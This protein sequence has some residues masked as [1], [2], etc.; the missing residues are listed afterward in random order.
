MDAAARH[1]A[2]WYG[3]VGEAWLHKRVR[4]WAERMGVQ[5]S[6]LRVLPL[7]YRW[8]SC[9]AGGKVSIHWAAMQLPPDLVDYVLVHELAHL[10]RHDH[11]PEFW[12]LVERAMPD[13]AA[14]RDRL[15]RLGP[16]LWLPDTAS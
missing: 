4:P 5:V 12:R 1:L 11:S 8:G 6:G 9:T 3:R 15:R 2:R 10:L 13:Y 14:R 7:G 16:D